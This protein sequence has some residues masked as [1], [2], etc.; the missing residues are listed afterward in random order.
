MQSY[1]ALF[2]YLIAKL[3]SWGCPE[4]IGG[5]GVQAVFKHN[6]YGSILA[7]VQI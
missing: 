5:E 2:S 4:R 1:N 7:L 6:G 3:I